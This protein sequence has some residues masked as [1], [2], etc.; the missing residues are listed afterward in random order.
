MDLTFQEKNAWG[1][2]LGIVIVSFF[3]FPTALEIVADVPQAGAL[4]GISIVGVIALIVIEGIYHAVIA[5]SSGD[6]TDERDRLI[7]LKAERNSG[8]VL[9]VGLFWL[10]GHIV[11]QSILNAYPVP[12]PLEIAV[13]ILL[14]ITVSEVGKLLSQIWY[15]R[16]GS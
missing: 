7:D 3:Y 16:I 15:Y 4:I 11:A 12:N 9:G 14:A 6:E 1:L 8:Y 10:V 2:L 13:Y 5:V